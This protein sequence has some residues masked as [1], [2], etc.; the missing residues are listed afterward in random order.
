MTDDWQ[1]GYQAGYQNGYEAGIN[2]A[3]LSVKDKYKTV[4]SIDEHYEKSYGK[5]I[6]E[7]MKRAHKDI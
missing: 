5:E 6:Y 4:E 1:N 2:A 7:K 3:L